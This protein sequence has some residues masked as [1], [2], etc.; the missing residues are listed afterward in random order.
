MTNIKRSEQCCLAS[1]GRFIGKMDEF[2][3]FHLEVEPQ[4]LS[5]RV[6][7]I[8][9]LYRKNH[10]ERE[11]VNLSISPSPQKIQPIEA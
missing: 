6:R 7:S 3:N 1:E 10:T 4:N 2:G 11:T 5:H 9:E 8:V